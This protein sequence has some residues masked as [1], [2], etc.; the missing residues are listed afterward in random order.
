M[1][2]NSTPLHH[3]FLFIDLLKI[4]AITLMIYNHV[5]NE[6][7]R[8]TEPNI[9]YHF[10]NLT[11]M[12]SALFLFLTGLLF[13]L[14]FKKMADQR[15]WFKQKTVR[16]I[17]LIAVSLVLFFLDPTS[18]LKYFYS[19]GILQ[20]I[21][22]LYLL[23]IPVLLIKSNKVIKYTLTSLY[24]LVLFSTYLLRNSGIFIP[25]L[26][27]YSFP[28]L[29]H[30]AYFLLGLLTALL[31]PPTNKLRS[32]LWQPLTISFVFTLVYLEVFIEPTVL[33][34]FELV[35]TQFG[36]WQPT[37]VL[38]CIISGLILG[39]YLVLRNIESTLQK[40]KRSNW[41]SVLS[42]YSLEIYVFH[43]LLIHLLKA[44]LFPD[45]YSA[46]LV[47]GILF[48]IIVSAAGYALLRRKFSSRA[49]PT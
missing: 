9:F 1:T 37:S 12:S 18:N 2:K 38:V 22:V 49:K 32:Y 47:L 5:F 45:I 35:I 16:A 25:F 10:N 21:G 3:R 34:L 46:Y 15:A 11:R 40:L 17:G 39:L 24:I 43:L 26:N 4:V 42:A 7:Y 27:S 33:V 6:W 23:T 20:L 44:T 28:L 41:I 14:S 8:F 19:S 30:T 48:G 13:M 36:Y 31:L 29:P